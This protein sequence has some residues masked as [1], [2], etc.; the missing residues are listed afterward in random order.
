MGALLTHRHGAVLTLEVSNPG[1]ANALDL[2]ILAQLDAQVTQVE[3]DRSVRVVVLRGSP[4]GTFSSGAD[5]RQW[6]PMTPEQFGRDWIAHGNA[7]FRRFESLRCPTV[8]AIEGL[9]FGGGLELALCADLRVGSDAA[10]LRFPEVGIGAI[11]GWEGGS[12]LALL[13]G[14]GRALEAVLTMRVLDAET[15]ERWGVLNAVWPAAQFESRLAEY[16]AVLSRV[17]PRAAALA[18]AAIVGPADPNSFY[19]AAG[20]EIKASPDAD[21]GI[22]AFFEKKTAEF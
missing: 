14:R 1:K 22:R 3:G 2:D 9:C 7:I 4:G 8:A 13:A 5:I 21:I 19:P 10:R 20:R 16:V 18:K 11:P 6:S 17:S 15:A 12:R